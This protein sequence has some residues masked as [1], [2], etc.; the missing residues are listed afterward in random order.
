MI[1]P[2]MS[3]FFLSKGLNQTRLM[4]ISNSALNLLQPALTYESV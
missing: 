3:S 4:P 2:L 1:V